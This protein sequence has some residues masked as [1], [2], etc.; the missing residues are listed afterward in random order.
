MHFIATNSVFV[1]VNMIR[2]ITVDVDV[3]V[4]DV[5][6]TIDTSVT[7]GRRNSEQKD[8]TSNSIDEGLCL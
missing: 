5:T 2:L 6:S 3:V 4:P 8:V 1:G 7:S